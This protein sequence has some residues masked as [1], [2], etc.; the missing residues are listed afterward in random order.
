MFR[1]STW[2]ARLA[3]V[4]VTVV[5]L[6]AA[7]ACGG[8]DEPEPPAEAVE[9]VEPDSADR[10]VSLARRNRRVVAAVAALP[11]GFAHDA[12]R[13]VACTACHAGIRGHDSHRD[14]EC[15]DCHTAGNV[16]AAVPAARECHACHHDASRADACSRCHTEPPAPAQT[17][18]AQFVFT[19]T[20][21]TRTRPLPFDHVLHAAVACRDC[22]SAGVELAVERG[23]RSCHDDH[24][25][26]AADCLQCHPAFPL[27]RHA[28]SSHLGC[29][30]SGCHATPR[31]AVP[32]PR[33]VCLVCHQDQV[34]HEPG[35][36]CSRCHLTGGAP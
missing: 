30:G 24:H 23:C 9:E 2:R 33:N 34:T 29:G 26:P 35:E 27:N 21:S 7:T 28:A 5:I 16:G 11:G 13:D 8:R 3:G 14:V 12:H 17:V 31:Y 20:D 22:H 19:A 32:Q 36:E 4:F 15:A 10:P 25:R 18:S 1:L 6:L